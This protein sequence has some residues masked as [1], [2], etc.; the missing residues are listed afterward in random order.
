MEVSDTNCNEQASAQPYRP[1]TMQG[2]ATE[3]SLATNDLI[4]SLPHV[5][6]SF[7]FSSEVVRGVA[8]PSSGVLP[9]PVVGRRWRVPG[10]L[11]LA[12]TDHFRNPI[13]RFHSGVL[14]IGESG[15]LCH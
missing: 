9:S 14:G 15:E 5:E 8:A 12:F 10:L 11:N 13:R 2:R 7:R 1:M 4:K 3:L 6:I